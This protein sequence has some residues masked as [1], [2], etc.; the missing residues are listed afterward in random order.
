[1][2]SSAIKPLSAPERYEEEFIRLYFNRSVAFWLLTSAIDRSLYQPTIL[3][4]NAGRLT[5]R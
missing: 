4:I 5:A 1:M 2:E 3:A